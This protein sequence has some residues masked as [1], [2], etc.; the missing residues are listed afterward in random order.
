MLLL[1]AGGYRRTWENFG[2]EKLANLV[3]RQ[4]FA[5]IFL[6]IIHRYTENLLAIHTDFSLFI[7]VVLTNS[8][9]HQKFPHQIFPMYGNFVIV[10]CH[11]LV[12]WVDVMCYCSVQYYW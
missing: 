11:S 5:K 10:L 9:V 8:M 1:A 2:R 4:P 3:N 12:L 7:K 6:A